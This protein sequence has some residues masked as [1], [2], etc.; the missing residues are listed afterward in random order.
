MSQQCRQ[1]QVIDGV[2]LLLL[3]PRAPR[4]AARS[5]PRA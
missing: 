1:A 4:C 3:L 5:A 2:L